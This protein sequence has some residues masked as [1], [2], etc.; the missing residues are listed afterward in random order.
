MPLVSHTGLVGILYA[1]K[2]TAYGFVKDDVDVISAFADQATVAIENSRLINESLARE[3]LIREMMLAQE[4]Q[5]RLL[6]Q[7]VPSHP[8]LELTPSPPRPLRW[9]AITMIS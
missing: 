9:G 8:S 7:T 2:D 4:M 3:R 6:P 1:T 5:R